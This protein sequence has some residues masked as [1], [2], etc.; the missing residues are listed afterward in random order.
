MKNIKIYETK[1]NIGMIEYQE[2]ED[3]ILLQDNLLNIKK[4]FDKF[5][6][7]NE[8][9]G[10]IWYQGITLNGSYVYIITNKKSNKKYIGE[11]SNLIS[12]MDSYIRLRFTNNKELTKDFKLYGFLNFEIE[13]IQTPKRK[14]LEKELI[15][16]IDDTYNITYTK[17]EKKKSTKK[18]KYIIGGIEF[19]SKKEITEFIRKSLDLKPVGYYI[20]NNEDLF[21]FSI[22][23]IRYNPSYEQYNFIENGKDIKLKVVIDNNDGIGKWKVFRFEW[24]NNKYWEFSTNK[25]IKFI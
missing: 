14:E 23:I 25:C 5:I 24:D 19:K 18:E 22:D 6:I 16:K 4:I 17:K 21:K 8:I 11:T 1:L 9:D 3:N 2:L 10:H 7:D 12:R 13:F 20:N 15:N